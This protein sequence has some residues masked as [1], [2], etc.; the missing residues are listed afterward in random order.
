MRKRVDGFWWREWIVPSFSARFI[1]VFWSDPN[2]ALCIQ[3]W[4]FKY[5]SFQCVFNA[6]LIWFRTNLCCRGR[7]ALKI[8][9]AQLVSCIF[10][11][12]WSFKILFVFKY[13]LATNVLLVFL[14]FFFQRQKKFCRSFLS[15]E[16][17]NCNIFFP[18]TC[19]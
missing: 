6:R 10:R 11:K 18:G 2:V 3:H 5:F 14:S 17:L 8:L 9:V 19:L 4:Y 12:G 16:V 15:S 1:L 7:F 13:L